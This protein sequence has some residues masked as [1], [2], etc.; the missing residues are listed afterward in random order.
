VDLRFRETSEKRSGSAGS[1]GLKRPELP[2]QRV[3]DRAMAMMIAAAIN[4]AVTRLI[5]H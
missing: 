1:E 3:I 5:P 4:G 2:H